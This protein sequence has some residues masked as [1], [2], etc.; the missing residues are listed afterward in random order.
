MS[1]RSARH[2][3]R[4]PV[5]L[6][7][8]AL[9]VS[10][11]PPS[12]AATTIDVW[13]GERH[14]MHCWTAPDEVRCDVGALYRLVLGRRPDSAGLDFWSAQVRSGNRSLAE[15]RRVLAGSG[16]ARN[17]VAA[18][19]DACLLRR[20]DSG[21]L[22]YRLG[23]LASGQSTMYREA[24]AISRS[25]EAASKGYPCTIRLVEPGEG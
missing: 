22:E 19:Y 8:S 16:E 14:A 4:L 18:I 12:A 11:A 7:A 17:R 10:L 1:R 6:L 5:L 2:V 13:G 15:V 24:Y 9:I 3:G 21:G 20:V 25:A 23:R